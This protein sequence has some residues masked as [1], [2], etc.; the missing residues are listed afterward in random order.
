[1]SNFLREIARKKFNGAEF[2]ER[3][4]EVLDARIRLPWGRWFEAEVEVN[5]QYR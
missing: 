1:M 4:I 2:L 3:K 5:V